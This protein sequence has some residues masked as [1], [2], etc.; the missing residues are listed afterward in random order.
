M[1]ISGV[2]E[3]KIQTKNCI[4]YFLK[5][6]ES[7]NNIELYVSAATSSSVSTTLNGGIQEFKVS[8]EAGWVQ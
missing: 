4:V 1:S 3:F 2:T 7:N 5:N 6:T 8:S